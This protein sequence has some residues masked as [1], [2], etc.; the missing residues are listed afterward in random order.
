MRYILKEPTSFS[1][2]IPPPKCW[3]MSPLID[4]NVGR[5]KT[6]ISHSPVT[7]VIENETHWIREKNKSIFENMT[8]YVYLVFFDP[9]LPVDDDLLGYFPTVVN[10]VSKLLF[11]IFE[12]K[13]KIWYL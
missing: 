4:R 6:K 13:L 8:L 12:V 11:I 1:L 2:E 7:I 9:E 5:V 3:F 10:R